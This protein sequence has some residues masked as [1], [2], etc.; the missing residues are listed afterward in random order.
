VIA[1]DGQNVARGARMV[2][3][4]STN[5]GRMESGGGGGKSKPSRVRTVIYPKSQT[6][7]PAKPQTTAEPAA[8]P[9]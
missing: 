4:V 1:I 5:D 6:D 3:K 2:I 8:A 7:K 9:H